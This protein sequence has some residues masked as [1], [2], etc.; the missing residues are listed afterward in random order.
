MDITCIQQVKTM[1]DIVLFNIKQ[2]IETDNIKTNIIDILNQN[3]SN[4]KQ[5]KNIN[6]YIDHIFLF[7]YDDS[8]I[9]INYDNLEIVTLN[10]V[11]ILFNKN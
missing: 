1:S 11:D 4:I 7:F 3:K 2:Y 8:Y 5:V 9:I 6:V 10:G